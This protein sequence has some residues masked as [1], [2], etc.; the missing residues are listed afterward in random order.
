[1]QTGPQP[2]EERGSRRESAPPLLPGVGSR[3]GLGGLE[4]RCA[5]TLALN[6][7]NDLVA[8]IMVWRSRALRELYYSMGGHAALNT[9][10]KQRNKSKEQVLN[11]R[12]MWYGGY[13]PKDTSMLQPA[14]RARTVLAQSDSAGGGETGANTWSKMHKVARPLLP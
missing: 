12:V 7:Y 8:K 6:I 3:A 14:H 9:A 13:I 11:V 2:A 5:H 10:K 4:A 1:M